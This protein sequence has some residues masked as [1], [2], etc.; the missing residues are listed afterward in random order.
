MFRIL[1]LI[2]AFF[3]L[4][5]SLMAKNSDQV[6]KHR[7]QLQV[8]DALGFPV[9]G[10]QFWVTI[11]FTKRGNEITLK[12]P[13]LNF[14]TGQVSTLNPTYPAGQVVTGFPLGGYLFTSNGF[15]PPDLRPNDLVP[16]SVIAASN[17]GMSPVFSFVQAPSTLPTPPTGYIVQVRND[18]SLQV[19]CAGTFGNIIPSGPQILMP[20]TIK[21]FAGK[22]ETMQFNF[23]LSTGQT[24][25]TQFSYP[26]A[27]DGV[28][29][30][31]VNDAFDGVFGWAWCDNSMIAD[32]TGGNLNA[33]VAIGRIDKKGEFKVGKPVQLTN[34]PPGVMAWDTAVAINRQDKNNIVVS[35]GVLDYTVFP[36]AS[37]SGRAVSFD[38]GK[39]WPEI[40][41]YT[42]F[43]GTI[44]GNTLTVTDVSFGTIEVGQVLNTYF[45]PTGIVAGT[46]IT[47][48]GTGTGGVGTYTVNI[49]Q[50]VP[51]PS[52]IVASWPLN[53]FIPIQPFYSI[54]FGDNRG[55]S[56]D[57][58]GNI[59]YVSTIFYS[60]MA[61]L[62]DE[63]IFFASSDGGVTFQ[64][65]YTVP[66]PPSYMQGTYYTDYPQ[67]CFGGDGSGNYGL[68]FQTT[69]YY[70]ADGDGWP[71]VGFIPIFGRGSFGTLTSNPPIS[72]NMLTNFTN[73]IGEMDLTASSDGRV[74]FKGG[75]AP[76][77]ENALIECPFNYIQPTLVMFKSPGAP[78]QNYSGA[79]GFGL[80]NSVQE[81]TV[82]PSSQGIISQP[83]VGFFNNSVQSIVYD[84]QRQALY[85]VDSTRTPD[86]SQNMAIYF[87]ISRDNGQSWSNPIEISN[88]NKGNRGFPSMALDP[89]TGNLV[90]GW[91]DG[92]NDPT[93]QSLGYYG[94]VIPAKKLDQLVNKIPLSN[95]LYLSP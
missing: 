16:P 88:T 10:S 33:M 4:N 61:E 50:T 91:Y 46:E 37:F 26:N 58:Y 24:N 54:G 62:V 68:W 89:V 56:A 82:P 43:T 83:Y 71:T 40:L 6:Y 52:Y 1:T 45:S 47:G 76:S 75:V 65:V 11:E 20:C 60:E 70:L 94:T 79:W 13:L 81:N 27:G 17:N 69:F 67:N 63:A 78:E 73:S 48:F 32:K 3:A 92:R 93:Y 66:L 59:W 55:V 23:P 80:W 41:D 29:D 21:Y 28:R 19:Q 90:F 9:E 36:P 86:N 64:N 2:C 38:G 74:W 77:I 57:K 87:K 84:E 51:A 39:T 49:S 44:A 5:T 12:V 14:T 53:G 31:H 30:T 25:T 7:M 18:G 22:N 95:P 34:L 72:Y 15:L 85:S 35:Y 42:A 8:A